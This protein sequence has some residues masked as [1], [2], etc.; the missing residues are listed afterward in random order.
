MLSLNVSRLEHYAWNWIAFGFFV[1]LGAFFVWST[2]GL[3]PVFLISIALPAV[4]L[5]IVT[6]FK[7]IQDK[8]AIFVCAIFLGYLS[9]SVLWGTGNHLKGIV[10]TLCIL[11][12]MLSVEIVS[13]RFSENAIIMFIIVT[14][15]IAAVSYVVAIFLSDHSIKILLES[16]YSFHEISGWGSKN[17]ID[18]TVIAGLP[19]IA[20][21]YFFPKKGWA[22]KLILAV[23]GM[24]CL[25]LMFVSKSRGPT[26]SV[27]ITLLFISIVR[28]ER[29]DLFLFFFIIAL[30]VVAFLLLNFSDVIVARVQSESYRP[31]LWREAW[32]MFVDHWLFGQG[33]GTS[34]KIMIRELPMKHPH[35][36]YID[37]LRIGGI[38]GGV[39]FVYMVSSMVR[40]SYIHSKNLF[41]LFWLFFGLMCM[42]VDDGFPLHYPREIVFF[43]FWIPLF[44]FYY[45]RK[46]QKHQNSYL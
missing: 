7:C 12:L 41:F 25:A 46:N 42:I 32:G 16:R 6:K 21:W 31:Y 45:L 35:N 14:G 23:T 10:C 33:Y 8:R 37:I 39:L 28:R 22:V 18:S 27:A 43:E 9:L 24:L 44:L 1:Y 30:T 26:I 40:F 17:I 5:C 36:T 34:A 11:F 3:T 4:L 20:S 19:V 2:G 29:S 15:L 38:V 13:R